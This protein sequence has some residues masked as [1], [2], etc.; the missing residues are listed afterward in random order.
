MDA[1]IKAAHTGKSAMAKYCAAPTKLFVN[2]TRV[3]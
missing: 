3:Q 1:I 2:R